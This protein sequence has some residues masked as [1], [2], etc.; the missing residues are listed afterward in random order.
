MSDPS[1]GSLLCFS[2]C[3]F[4]V[5]ESRLHL[6]ASGLSFYDAAIE[7]QCSLVFG[8]QH[9]STDILVRAKLKKKISTAF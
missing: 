6:L 5:G 8:Q 3:L 9:N 7:Q 2:L 1:E 4:S